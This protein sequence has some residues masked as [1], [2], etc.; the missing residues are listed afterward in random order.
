LGLHLFLFT[1]YSRQ[2]LYSLEQEQKAKQEQGDAASVQSIDE[3]IV[4]LRFL[5]PRYARRL[6]NL[7]AILLGVYF[8]MR[9]F[10]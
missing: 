2:L 9:I 8:I 7:G 4:L 6:F 1:D 3:E 5:T 10:G